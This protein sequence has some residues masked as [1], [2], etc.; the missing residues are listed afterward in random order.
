MSTLAEIETAAAIEMV[1][2]TQIDIRRLVHP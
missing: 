1:E 2:M